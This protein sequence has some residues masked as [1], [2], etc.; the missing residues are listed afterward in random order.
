[1]QQK[2]KASKN[3]MKNKTTRNQIRNESPSKKKKKKERIETGEILGQKMERTTVKF[4]KVIIIRSK[5]ICLS[6]YH[7]LF[8]FCLKTEF[9]KKGYNIILTYETGLCLITKNPLKN[10]L[11]LFFVFHIIES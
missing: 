11:K 5:N 2:K 6:N 9:G 4:I 10:H 8:L 1:M 7:I 3:F